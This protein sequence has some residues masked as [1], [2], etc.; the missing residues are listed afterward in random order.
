MIN[1]S[2]NDQLELLTHSGF[3][4]AYLNWFPAPNYQDH[5]FRGVASSASHSAGPKGN[6]VADLHSHLDLSKLSK[7]KKPGIFG[8][9]HLC[10][11][12]STQYNQNYWF[13]PSWPRAFGIDTERKE[14]KGCRRGWT[15][16]KFI[17]LGPPPH[18]GIFFQ[19]HLGSE[20]L[21]DFL[22]YS[23]LNV[24]G[25]VLAAR[26]QKWIW[27]DKVASQVGSQLDR[28]VIPNH[29]LKEIQETRWTWRNPYPTISI[30]EGFLEGMTSKLGLKG[31]K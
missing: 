8:C 10:Q 9:Y 7:D 18:Q 4:L 28:Q 21:T 13:F 14:R 29:R 25:P 5:P 19:R 16:R 2:C 15:P 17:S 11:A 1:N 22:Q 27:A 23:L 20:P 24:L 12:Q 31:S 3:W 6:P 30:K 26:V